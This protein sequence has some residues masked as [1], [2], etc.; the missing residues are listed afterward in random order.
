M[1]LIIFNLYSEY[2]TKESLEGYGN[3][4]IGRRVIHTV[5]C[6]D[7]LCSCLRKKGCYRV[8]LRDHLELESAVEWKRM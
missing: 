1:S 8:R 3:F 5:N 6:G 7:T 4:K 2:L